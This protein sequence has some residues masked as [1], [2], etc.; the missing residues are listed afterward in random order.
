MLGQIATLIELRKTNRNA[1]SNGRQAIAYR[2]RTQEQTFFAL[3]LPRQNMRALLGHKHAVA[4]GQRPLPAGMALPN[5][6]R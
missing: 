1:A 3:R 2:D 6:S 5:F 4:I